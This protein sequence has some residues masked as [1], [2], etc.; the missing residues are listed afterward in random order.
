MIWMQCCILR[1][2]PRCHTV[3]KGISRVDP[4]GCTGLVC[5]TGIYHGCWPG[6]VH[7]LR[8]CCSSLRKR[9]FHWNWKLH[10][11]NCNFAVST[12]SD[13]L[14][15]YI[16]MRRRIKHHHYYRCFTKISMVLDVVFSDMNNL[17]LLKDA[18]HSPQ[19]SRRTCIMNPTSDPFY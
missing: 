2:S 12:W 11:N 9:N 14:I 3:S 13:F 17:S 8:Q 5:S 7:F 16:Y 6:D 10:V 19:G 15:K 1:C 4:L 18:N